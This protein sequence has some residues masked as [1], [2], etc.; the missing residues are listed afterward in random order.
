[1][2][3]ILAERLTTISE[4]RR[5]QSTSWRAVFRANTLL[6]AVLRSQVRV[7]V[8]IDIEVPLNR[9]LRD[10]IGQLTV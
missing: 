9:T 4:R 6:A 3:A 5:N 8:K 7:T 10:E 1:M 2:V